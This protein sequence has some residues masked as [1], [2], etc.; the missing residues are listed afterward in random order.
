MPRLK[1]SSGDRGGQS[2]LDSDFADEN[3]QP[4]STAGVNST[5]ES[6]FEPTTY[7][8]RLYSPLF[9]SS[10]EGLTI[11]TQPTI[12][13]TALTHALGYEIP[14]IK[15]EKRY[16]ERGDKA[17]TPTYDHLRD[18]DLFCSDMTPIVAAVDERTFRTASYGTENRVVTGDPA[19]AKQVDVNS[20]GG[21][22]KIK[23]NSGSI[24]GWKEVQRYTG[25]SPGAEY[26]FTVWTSE[27]TLPDT[28]R[29]S[30]G[31]SR[32]GEFVAR[33][34][35][36]PADTVTLNA[37]LLS[38]VYDLGDIT[39]ADILEHAENYERGNDPRLI[40][41]VGVDREWIDETLLY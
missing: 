37:F 6:H 14:T 20:S 10:K 12:A 21:S 27:T 19:V 15:L 8:A 23:A 30:M 29:F 32:S 35:S 33:K 41:Y 22:P 31:I 34:Q 24:S 38:E 4:T 16:V 40:H 5:D 3:D 18:L 39:P 11:E 26:E 17:T 7:R 9:Y 25:I 28:L 2:N 13:A 1:T 36:E